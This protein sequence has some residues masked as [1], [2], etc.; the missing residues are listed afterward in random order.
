MINKKGF[1]L[2]ELLIV[3]VIIGILGAIALPRF[4]PKKEKARVAEAI[5]ILAAIR[6]G[7]AAY[8]LEH[9]G[10]CLD[11]GAG[12]SWDNLGISD[13]NVAGGLFTYTVAAD[14]TATATRT[15]AH[16]GDAR[17]TIILDQAGTWSGTHPMKPGDN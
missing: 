16:D 14:G 1:T 5:G 4:A 8:A 13:P 2:T 6:Q 7:C 10:N 12:D 9:G 17:H 15:A 11:L 3:I